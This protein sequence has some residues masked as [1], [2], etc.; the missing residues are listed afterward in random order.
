MRSRYSDDLTKWLV[1]ALREV[2]YSEDRSAAETFD[3]QGTFKQQ[4]DTGQNL[5]YLI[6]YPR[7][8]CSAMPAKSAEEAVVVDTQSPQYIITACEFA[9]FKEI[10][11]SK[12][13]SWRQRKRMLKCLQES[14]EQFKAIEE[15]LISGAPLTA[16]EQSRYDSNSGADM[17]KINWLQTLIKEMVD[18]GFL[19]ESEKEELIASLT[20]NLGSVD[21]EIASAQSEGKPKKVEKLEEKKRS[22]QER[23]LKITGIAPIQ[24]RLKHAEELIRLRLKLFP[25]VS[26]E[27]KGRS[28]SLTIADLKTLE[29][30]GDIEES[31]I[32]LENASRCWFED[33]EEFKLRCAV[34]AKEAKLKYNAF[35]K[36]QAAKKPSGGGGGKSTGTQGRSASSSS[37]SWAVAGTGYKKASSSGGGTKK[38]SGGFAAAFADDDSD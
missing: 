3:S 21:E 1:A 4:H 10:A 14:Y 11:S 6:V 23:K 34:E 20:T 36:A 33:E 37:S 12:T 8:S 30:K 28:M 27:E 38:A 7:V 9:T 31:I 35:L 2:G 25:L 13:M 19:T 26:L 32:Q 22:I 15:K 29:Q 18:G 16:S 24:H 17:D 5:K